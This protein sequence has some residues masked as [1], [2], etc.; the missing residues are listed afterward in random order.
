MKKNEISLYYN[1]VF[2]YCQHYIPLRSFNE[3]NPSLKPYTNWIEA[4]PDTAINDIMTFADYADTQKG[5]ALCIPGTVKER[6]QAKAI[7]IYQ[8][9][10]ICID[11][12]SGD[13]DQKK[14]YA[15]EKIGIPTLIVASGGITEEGQHKLH[16]YW[17]LSEAC[18]GNELNR[19]LECRR[20]LALKV[21]A[22]I[23]FASAHQPIRIA[24][25]IYHKGDIPK[26]TSILEFNDTEYHLYELE[27]IIHDI[28]PLPGIL[29][30]THAV[31]NFT[32]NK[33]SINELF[34]KQ[35]RSEGKDQVSRF[36][37]L[38]SVIGHWLY[39]YHKGSVTQEE[40]W[41]RISSY[42]QACIN[43]PWDEARLHAETTRLWEKHCRQHGEPI[44]QIESYQLED[45]TLQELLND[46]SPMP[47]SYIEKGLLT[48][49]GLMVFAGPPK[50]GKSAFILSM[51]MHL[52]E[53][54]AYLDFVPS[55]PLNIYYLQAEVE[56]AWMKER[57]QDLH[58]LNELNTEN[59]KNLIISRSTYIS[60]T[61][62][63]IEKI[64]T[65]IRK[66]SEKNNFIPDII[67]I[68]P[69][70]NFYH[71]ENKGDEN[72]VS[73]MREFWE[74]INRIRE[75]VN[76]NAGIILVHHCKKIDK[77]LLKDDVFNAIAGSGGL[78]GLYTTGV[79]FYRPDEELPNNLRLSFEARN[80]SLRESFLIDKE[81]LREGGKFI[82]HGNAIYSCA[83][84]A[85]Q[86]NNATRARKQEKILELIATEAE[87]GRIYG[88]SHF[89]ERFEGKYNIGSKNTIIDRINVL[90][91]NGW[92]RF[93][94]DP[95]N[96]G[97]TK[98]K[99]TKPIY[100][101]SICNMQLL[102]GKELFVTIK[103]DYFKNKDVGY[104]LVE[105]IE[106]WNQNEL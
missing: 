15:I 57:V 69:L 27:D 49:K 14:K 95:E 18:E 87:Q 81:I 31:L 84:K 24:G 34:T 50:I 21:G 23:H 54:K 51:L 17:K 83:Y 53:G 44:K 28:L 38:S 85:E 30:K 5:S 97:F 77:N 13:I 89:A 92:I 86:K 3:K 33:I 62:K 7:D 42:N 101:M 78:R 35:I 59:N 98:T 52:A 105:N 94:K 56:Q 1:T 74:R 40:A 2:S 26:E 9:Q 48:R 79:L 4:N 104:S 8:M 70:R 80:K 82:D 72:T 106:L 47:E 22:D 60:L 36:S 103:P 58:I 11:I 76:P 88:I 63:G 45:D 20:V 10:V 39:V 41:E 29:P 46:N 32:E 65:Q 19:L 100:Y 93:F 37:A 75:A 61:D 67:C 90:A 102:V 25:T 55:R 16:I 64:S 91:T 71:S 43:P 99:G 12:D 66:S 96:Y 68:D 73:G 6:G